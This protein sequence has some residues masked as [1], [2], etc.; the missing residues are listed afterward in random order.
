MGDRVHVGPFDFR[1]HFD[2]ENPEAY[3]DRLDFTDLIVNARMAE[4][5]VAGGL[6]LD[7][8]GVGHGR[9][10]CPNDAN[11]DQVDTDGDGW[12]DVC[13]NCP[14]WYNPW[15]EDYD[16][17]GIGDSCE[18]RRAWYVKADRTGDAPT[19]QA[20]IDSSFHGDTVLVARG[21]YSGDGNWD[22]SPK[23]KQILIRS[24]N[25][26]KFTIIDCS[27]VSTGPH[28]GFVFQNGED[29]RTVIDGFTIHRGDAM[30][31]GGMLCSYRTSPLVVNCIFRENRASMGGGVCCRG[32]TTPEFVNCVFIKNTAS[33]AWHGSGG[34]M[35]CIENSSPR[36]E[37]CAFSGNTAVSEGGA[38][39][40]QNSAPILTNCTLVENLGDGIGGS[41][42][43]PVL[44][45][46]IIAFN[47]QGLAIDCRESSPTLSCCD[48][49][50]N[51]EGDWVGYISDQAG[52]DGNFSEDPLFCNSADG[53]YSI[54]AKSPCAP[55]YNSCGVQIGAYGIGCGCDCSG[56]GDCDDDGVITAV[57]VVYLLDYLYLGGS[58]PSIDPGCPVVNRGDFD[59]DGRV[60]LV[61]VVALVLYLH[62]PIGAGPCDP[63]RP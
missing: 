23:G 28:R 6:D 22:L 45:N 37:N 16:Q 42:S 3:Y 53:D 11:P 57:D 51:A 10:N 61:D 62:S 15:Q 7:G 34:G 59:C 30:Y 58:P 63:C 43:S 49:Y 13:D 19:I 9:D 46:C 8:D 40:L 2:P 35:A 21:T 44:E 60:S 52:I 12:G 25:G 54:N 50:G 5:L 41:Y 31:G 55:R 33:Y 32:K 26:P 18:V 4:W 47:E 17:D 48:L 24:E 36:L 29:S 20:A 1:D 14:C 39:Y 27:N 38:I 56:I